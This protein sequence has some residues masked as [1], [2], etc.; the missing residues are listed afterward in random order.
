MSQGKNNSSTP[1]FLFIRLMG[2]LLLLSTW[3][4]NAVSQDD[5]KVKWW[6]VL[7]GPAE[8]AVADYYPVAKQVL[9]SRYQSEVARLSVPSYN[10]K[11]IS[12][13]FVPDPMYC[14]VNKLGSDFGSV[15]CWINFTFTT[16]LYDNLGNVTLWPR[17][18]RVQLRFHPR[19]YSTANGVTTSKIA[20]FG[21]TTTW[22]PP[23]CSKTAC[24]V[25]KDCKT[26]T[27]PGPRSCNPIS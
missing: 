1:S 3:S 2:I 25:G 13:G 5:F 27:D 19:C 12:A 4:Q 7:T 21:D 11:V 9:E 26:K 10:P 14:S 18:G 16:Y 6:Y 20:S 22:Q 15:D 17:N 23:Y 24:P 8:P